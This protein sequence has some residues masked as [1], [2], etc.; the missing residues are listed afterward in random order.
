MSTKKTA[1]RWTSS[2]SV[3]IT[4]KLMDA[5][6]AKLIYGIE[7]VCHRFHLHCDSIPLSADWLNQCY[8]PTRT[9]A[10]VWHSLFNM[11]G[12]IQVIGNGYVQNKNENA[13]AHLVFK[14]CKKV[15]QVVFCRL[16]STHNFDNL[17]FADTLAI[18]NGVNF[19]YRTMREAIDVARQDMFVHYAAVHGERTHRHD[20]T[21][22]DFQS[23]ILKPYVKPVAAEI[24]AV[25][26][27]E[28]V[29]DDENVNE[30]QGDCE[31]GRST[32]ADD[33]GDC[34]YC[35]GANPPDRD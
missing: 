22:C 1:K 29:E 12:V 21:W 26:P 32:G 13:P 19:G 35:G 28:A 15:Y 3:K 30:P 14:S 23:V 17:T 9:I 24:A 11:T 16:G 20:E 18:E 5:Q 7:N 27:V 6:E 25:K 33:N 2:R 10:G 31:C 8:V 34:C 4:T